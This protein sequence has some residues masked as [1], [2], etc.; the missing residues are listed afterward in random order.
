MNQFSQQ[1]LACFYFQSHVSQ[2]QCL[3]LTV[4]AIGS[5]IRNVRALL[6]IIQVNCVTLEYIVPILYTIIENILFVGGYEIRL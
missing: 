4:L 2:W 3:A 6:A 1:S 5:I